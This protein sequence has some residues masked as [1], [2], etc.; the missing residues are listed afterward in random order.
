MAR[1]RY[2]VS[3]IEVRNFTSHRDTRLCVP[4]HG[5]LALV[6]ENGAGKS[7]ILEALNIALTG[8]AWRGNLRD[9]IRSGTK[10]AM[11]KVEL[12]DPAGGGR[13][14]LSLDIT[15]RGLQKALLVRGDRALAT[16]PRAYKQELA[17]LLGARSEKELKRIVENAVLI[18]QG[19]L[20]RI[21]ESMGK[22]RDFYKTIEEAL[23]IPGIR[24]AA[25][26]IG[27]IDLAVDLDP[28]VA[29]PSSSLGGADT[30]SRSTSYRRLRDRIGRLTIEVAEKREEAQRLIEEAQRLE[31]EAREA[32]RLLDTVQEKL[33]EAREAKGA[34]DQVEALLREALE[35]LERVREEIKAKLGEAERLEE[36][37]RGVEEARRLAGLQP[38]L[39]EATSLSL[40]LE[41][42][43]ARLEKA[44]EALSL[45]REAIELAGSIEELEKVE[46]RLHSITAEEAR[47]E[48]EREELRS[49]LG[50]LEGA[51]TRLERELDRAHRLLPGIPRDPAGALS[52]LEEALAALDKEIEELE[53]KATGLEA[54]A[55][56]AEREAVE[57]ERALEALRASQGARCPVC[58]SPL[59]EERRSS[60]ESLLS[61]KAV[62]ARRQ[63]REAKA[64]A[65][66]LRRRAR[67]KRREK[68][69]LARAHEALKAA[70]EDYDPEEHE[71]V[72]RE[73]SRIEGELEK[74][75]EEKEKL[76]SRKGRLEEA[77]E[78]LSKI[79]GEL[80]KLLE[81]LGAP[82]DPGALESMIEELE[83]E[84]KRL[85]PR[86]EKVREKLLAETGAGSL[87]EARERIGEAAKLLPGLEEAAR[88][89]EVVRSELEGLRAEE[90]ELEEK[91][92]GLRAEAERLKSAVEGL[93][94]L[95]AEEARLQKL[96]RENMER[97]AGNKARAE[98]A[99][100]EA[101]RLQAELEAARVVR[102]RMEAAYT[103]REMLEHLQSALM[104]RA[105]DSLNN[106]M[107]DVLES[108]N[109][110]YKAVD[111]RLDKDRVTVELIH[112][113]HGPGVG[114]GQLSGGEKTAL[115]LAYV[116]GLQ[117]ILNVGLDFLA[118]D[119]PTSEL[120]Q[121]RR[122]VLLDV[123][124]Q[125]TGGG[126]VSQLLVVTHHEEI[127]DKVDRVCRVVK[128]AGASRLQ[129]PEGRPCPC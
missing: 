54:Q 56:S 39:Q 60:L 29:L 61:G 53:A 108:F 18:Q 41:R 20:R 14:L 117:R 80:G 77:R 121:E 48:E 69:R 81:E 101:E 10:T 46:A 100:R 49:R 78:R 47:L 32:Q 8:E 28:D 82:R 118:L 55:A 95:E 115:A 67:E 113:I 103:V 42:L 97:A 7:S 104:K 13:L 58:G 34:L 106:A 37:A 84:R 12:V 3:R 93:G 26:K 98:E 75:G 124:G 27:A 24:E 120:D 51:R 76:L 83:A 19:G 91:I 102:R 36:E 74:L 45:L 23:G 127:A 25:K 6:G 33:R 107:N 72:A 30:L 123:L 2:R 90:A 59:D 71:R 38:L 79:E 122:S 110:D 87:E 52:A 85:L 64:R 44:R 9:I 50:R 125:T 57:A 66:A 43:E 4:T 16:Q 129:D 62:E 114:V 88:K 116:L 86:L 63:A 15:Q 128:E 68:D 31:E 73:L 99:R 105:V 111:L 22:P 17:R 1:P 5:S 11:V 70:I 65:Q 109:L 119:E 21:A 94:E 92:R 89:L 35:R 126:A 96:I 112:R 40:E